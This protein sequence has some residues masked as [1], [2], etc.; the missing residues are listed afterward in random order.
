MEFVWFLRRK[1]ENNCF[2]ELPTIR[3]F[4]QKVDLFDLC[5]DSTIIR[6]YLYYFN[7]LTLIIK[8][9]IHYELSYKG[10][11]LQGKH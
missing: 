11:L 1:F 3:Q 6:K 8:K 10:V 2:N 5:M 7:I 9:K 4:C